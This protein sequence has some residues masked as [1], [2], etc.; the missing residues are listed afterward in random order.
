MS[1]CAFVFFGELIDVVASD[2]AVAV[3]GQACPLLVVFRSAPQGA[4]PPKLPRLALSLGFRVILE[5]TAAG[6]HPL[7]GGGFHV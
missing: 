6:D 2:V 4:G 1:A 7:L 3:K 5:A